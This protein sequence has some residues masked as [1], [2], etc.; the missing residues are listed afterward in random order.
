MQTNG[1][2]GPDLCGGHHWLVQWYENQYMWWN[3][4]RQCHA[5]SPASLQ[6]GKQYWEQS[7][8]S[9]LNHVFLAFFLFMSGVRED[10]RRLKRL[11]EERNSLGNI[12]HWR[13]TQITPIELVYCLFTRLLKVTVGLNIYRTT[14]GLNLFLVWVL[15]RCSG[16]QWWLWHP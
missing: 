7:N 14:T 9:G 12:F 2:R 10:G 16:W 5:G 11:K 6:P 3:S 13:Q 1:R 15:W 4:T 8:V